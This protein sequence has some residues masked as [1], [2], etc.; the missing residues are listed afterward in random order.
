MRDDPGPVL[1]RRATSADRLDHLLEAITD[2]ARN[3]R[4][5]RE[6]V[7]QL[8]GR[9]L[10]AA[11][12]AHALA[13]DIAAGRLWL[14]LRGDDVIAAALVVDDCVRAIWVQP[15]HRRHKVASQ[16]LDALLHSDAPPHDAW[17]LPGDRA[18]KS[19][20]ESVGWKARLLTMRGE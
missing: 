5:G 15:A 10:D 14:A 9:D 20:Y 4:G 11:E 16:L 2:R 3:V 6:L 8:W 7:V 17:A 18:T 1:V 12:L 13:G 19:L